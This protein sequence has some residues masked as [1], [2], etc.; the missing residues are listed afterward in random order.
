MR[1][2]TGRGVL[3][4]IDRLLRN[5]TAAGVADGCLLEQFLGRHDEVAEA[6][7]AA[8]VE[9]HGPM[10]MRVCWRA[11]RDHHDAQDAF[12]ATFLVLARRAG[13]VRNRGSLV[14]WLYGVARRVSSHA[15]V[16]SAR[17]REIEKRAA[18]RTSTQIEATPTE[19]D[20]WDE[21]DRLPRDLRHAVILCYLE[22]LTHE[23]AAFRLG[24][25][26]RT[27][28]SRLARARDRLRIRLTRR[29]LGPGAASAP[30][31]SLKAPALSWELISPLAR[32]AIGVAPRDAAAAGLVSTSAIALTQGVLHTMYFVKLK[33][34]AAVVLA[35]GALATGAAVWGYQDTAPRAEARPEAAA[36][37]DADY[38]DV[39]EFYIAKLEQ[40][41]KSAR[42]RR[43]NPF[44]D[45]VHQDV[46]R[47][48][49][50]VGQ[51]KNAVKNDPRAREFATQP[52]RAVN[53]PSDAPPPAPSP[54]AA[55]VARMLDAAGTGREC[56]V[57]PKGD[58]ASCHRPNVPVPVP[59]APGAAPHG[60]TPPSNFAPP[61]QGR[62]TEGE[63]QR[64]LEDL[65]RKVDRILRAVEKDERRNPRV[66]EPATRED[67]SKPSGAQPGGAQGTASSVDQRNNARKE[68]SIGSDDG[69]APGHTL[70]ID[71]TQRPASQAER[72]K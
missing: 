41:L 51:W 17:R 33:T 15:R 29:G 58:C 35:A 62:L 72:P 54:A 64:R 69:L 56:P 71:R 43:S 47:I 26:V 18:A 32:A 50:I 63:S 46:I 28:R 3:G 45:G 61:A 48:E 8:L 42:T 40:A 1:A 44:V 21:V 20:L 12:Q 55:F 13:S 14:D 5:G 19:P 16:A 30:F 38:T 23:Q 9:R 2:R 25:P 70:S 57:S 39:S 36:T 67:S 4:Q 59:T 34:A 68:I 31:L 7:F 27:V 10:V 65:E 60:A 37:G 11:L 22:G 66:R 53:K 6:A 52:G 49:H 24:W